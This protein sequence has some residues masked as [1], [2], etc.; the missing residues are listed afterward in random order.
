MACLLAVLANLLLG[1]QLEHPQRQRGVFATRA[2]DALQRVQRHL[3]PGR[4]GGQEEQ[5]V[6]RAPRHRTQS[7]KQ[8][9]NGLADTGGGL[10]QQ[11]SPLGAG[12]VNRAGQ[13]TLPRAKRF[14]RKRQLFQCVVTLLP[15]RRLQLG[16]GQEAP[17]QVLK[18][19][20]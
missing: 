19:D 5:L 15:M 18:K 2:A 12:P 7:R 8:R 16:P 9:A 17:A 20:P 10:R 14:L 4:L 3:P 11:W 1:H 6:Q 13:P